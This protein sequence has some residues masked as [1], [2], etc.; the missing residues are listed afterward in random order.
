MTAVGSAPLD[1]PLRLGYRPRRADGVPPEASRYLERGT[2]GRA[3][4]ADRAARRAGARDVGRAAGARGLAVRSRARRRAE[5]PPR[6]RPLRRA[7]GVGEGVRP[8]RG[9]ALRQDGG[10]ADYWA[11]ASFAEA[12]L[13]LGDLETARSWYLRAAATDRRDYASL[14]STRLQARELLRHRG[15]DERALDACLGIPVVI[16][17]SVHMVDAPNRPRPRFPAEIEPQVASAI[18]AAAGGADILFLEPVL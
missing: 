13:V 15:D 5:A 11:E 16:A 1:G 12:A 8:Q 7:A 10:G 9:D 17:F 6:S 2:A 18:A 4:E 3:R 14:A